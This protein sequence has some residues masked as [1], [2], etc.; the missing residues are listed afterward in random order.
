[1]FRG[2]PIR[3]EQE[4]QWKKLEQKTTEL[5][6]GVESGRRSVD[7]DSLFSGKKSMSFSNEKKPPSR[8]P[9][10]PDHRSSLESNILM[11]T[12]FS[13][14]QERSKDKRTNQPT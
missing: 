14:N 4:D 7:I 12:N 6:H 11:G 9:P 8:S 2:P 13:F 3:E 5:K 1:M 10:K